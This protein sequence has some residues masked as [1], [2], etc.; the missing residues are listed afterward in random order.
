MPYALHKLWQTGQEQDKVN[1][2][3]WGKQAEN[4]C[5]YTG[6]GSK[7]MLQGRLDSRLVDNNGQKTARLDLIVERGEYLSMKK[8]EGAD[9]T[10]PVTEDI[11]VNGETPL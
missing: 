6:K 3:L 4:A 9:G 1:F 10:D 5:K 8:D 7:V 11:E 2:L